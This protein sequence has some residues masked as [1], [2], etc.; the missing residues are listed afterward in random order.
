M[1]KSTLNEKKKSGNVKTML[2]QHNL[3]LRNNRN[4]D[5]INEQQPNTDHQNQQPPNSRAKSGNVKTMLDN[6]KN[7]QNNNNSNNENRHRSNNHNTQ[8]QYADNPPNNKPHQ[9]SHSDFLN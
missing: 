7:N 5:S 4:N 9:L 6:Y 8:S 3:E 2:D 1:K